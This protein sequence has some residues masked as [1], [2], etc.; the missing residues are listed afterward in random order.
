LNPNCTEPINFAYLQRNGVPTG[1]P[2][3]QRANLASS[4]QNK[5]TLLMRGGEVL[6]VSLGDALH[7]GRAGFTARITD[8]TTGRTGYMIASARNGFMDTNYR[9]C[10]GRPFTFHAEYATARAAN[11]VPW[12][13]LDGGV[14]MQQEIGHSEICAS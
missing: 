7:G 10:E 6:G 12:A 1:P 2:R 9:T 14:L 3:P 13:L 8:L 11:S 4:T 5:R